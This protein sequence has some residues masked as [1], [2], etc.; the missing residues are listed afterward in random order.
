MLAEEKDATEFGVA[1]AM[2]TGAPVIGNAMSSISRQNVEV[3]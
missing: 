3:R 2:H 1:P